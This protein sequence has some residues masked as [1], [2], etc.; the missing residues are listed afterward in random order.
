MLITKLSFRLYKARFFIFLNL[1]VKRIMRLLHRVDAVH[2]DKLFNLLIVR[3]CDAVKVG[4]HL[5]FFVA[6]L[7]V[8]TKK[9][10]ILTMILH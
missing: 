5:R 3:Q 1:E 7:F 4:A 8:R 9:T 10:K 2:A 6:Q